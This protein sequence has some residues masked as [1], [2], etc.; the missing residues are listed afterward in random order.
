MGTVYSFSSILLTLKL[1]KQQ[2]SSKAN[3]LL[4]LCNKVVTSL[5]QKPQWNLQLIR[6]FHLN[7]NPSLLLP[8]KYI[9]T[10]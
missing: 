9:L 4:Q 6:I 7:A 10:T 1:I 5:F 8:S 2:W 3:S